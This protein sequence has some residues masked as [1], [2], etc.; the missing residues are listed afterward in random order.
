MCSVFV[1]LPQKNTTGNN[2]HSDNYYYLFKCVLVWQLFANQTM[3]YCI[4]TILMN[5]GGFILYLKKID[6]KNSSLTFT[7]IELIFKEIN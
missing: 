5:Y 3:M 4:L 1:A 2:C 7:C 6:S